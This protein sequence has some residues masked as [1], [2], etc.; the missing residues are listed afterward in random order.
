[1]VQ[2]SRYKLQKDVECKL[3]ELL[4]E[5]FVKS[6]NKDEFNKIFN[7]IFSPTERV[8]IIKRI[9]IFYLK[10]QKVPQET[11]TKVLHVSSSTVAK[12]SIISD[13]SHGII[14]K[15]NQILKNRNKKLLVLEIVNLLF[16]S[17]QYGVNWK[18]SWELKKEIDKTK[19]T[20][21]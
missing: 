8:M 4:Y 18:G 16:P 11:I 14:I 6:N 15:L 13:F 1:M 19:Q 12:F 5:V 10:I 7:D 3:N 17:G 9:A 2:V 20:G 21:L